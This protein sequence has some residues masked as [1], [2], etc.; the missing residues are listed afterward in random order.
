MICF[1][2]QNT[3]LLR[4]EYDNETISLAFISLHSSYDP[5]DLDLC[6]FDDVILFEGT[7]P[8]FTKVDAGVACRDTTRIFPIEYSMF[9]FRLY[10]ECQSMKGQVISE[11]SIKY[12]K[13]YYVESY[14]EKNFIEKN[15]TVPKYFVL[16]DYDPTSP[17]FEGCKI[18]QNDTIIKGDCND[19]LSVGFCV[20]KANMEVSI[21]GMFKTGDIY[22]YFTFKYVLSKCRC[23]IRY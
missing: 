1:G 5:F 15:I 17:N 22:L 3:S 21:Y 2:T 19:E 4:N 18:M 10:Y 23:F 8:Q 12:H 13:D 14:L 7:S 11:I 9:M 16:N 6:N 20:F